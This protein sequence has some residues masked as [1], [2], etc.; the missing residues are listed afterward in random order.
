MDL[1]DLRRGPLTPV[2]RLR[3]LAGI[4]VTALCVWAIVELA[5]GMLP[6]CHPL[7]R[8]VVWLFLGGLTMVPFG[9][10]L[11]WLGDDLAFAAVKGRRTPKDALKAFFR[12]LR[13]GYYGYAYECMHAEERTDMPRHRRAIRA[14]GVTDKLCSFKDLRGFHQYWHDIVQPA[15]KGARLK[16]RRFR[17][18]QQLSRDEA[19]VSCIVSPGTVFAIW[20]PWWIFW[21]PVWYSEYTCR[22]GTRIDIQVRELAKRIGDKW[23]L[24]NGELQGPKEHSRRSPLPNSS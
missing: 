20:G 18:E 22:L 7:E 24:A 14:L 6:D 19:W 12:A 16:L 15:N 21:R 4:T 11:V 10:T 8:I 23:F 5:Y 17:L 9:L 2:L 3:T 13:L 1:F